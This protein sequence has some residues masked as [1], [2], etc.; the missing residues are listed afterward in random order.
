MLEHAEQ[1]FDK[2]QCLDACSNSITSDV[3]FLFSLLISSSSSRLGFSKVRYLIC[4]RNPSLYLNW[5]GLESLVG[6]RILL[7]K[8]L[9][10]N[11]LQ[12]VIM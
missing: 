11:P 6:F 2:R 1:N 8:I 4:F 5:P 9:R 7:G 12:L 10:S 3:L